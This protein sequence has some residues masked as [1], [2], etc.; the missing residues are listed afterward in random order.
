MI[1]ISLLSLKIKRGENIKPWLMAGPFYKDV[2]E[3]VKTI[4]FFENPGSLAGK[5]VMREVVEEARKI[6]PLSPFEGE[7]I[8]FMDEES[9]WV[10]VRNRERLFSW[11]R[12]NFSNHVCSVFLFT[13]LFPTRSKIVRFELLTGA[14]VLMF[15]EGKGQRQC[16]FFNEESYALKERVRLGYGYLSKYEFE[17]KLGEGSNALFVSLFRMGRTS[18][19][20]FSMK[21]DTDLEIV[22]PFRGDM[23]VGLRERIEEEVNSVRLDRDVFYPCHEIGFSIDKIVP[24]VTLKA[25]LLSLKGELL[26]EVSLER[27]KKV[28]FCRGEDIPDGEYQFRLIWLDKNRK[29]EVT[30]TSFNIA[31]ITPTEDLVG[32]DFL[33]RRKYMTLEHF[34]KNPQSPNFLYKELWSPITGYILGEREKIWSQ[35]AKYALG[36]YSQIDNEV[37]VDVCEFILNKKDCSEFLL[38]AILRLMYWDREKQRLEPEVREIMKKAILNFR[39]WVDE[40]GES[41]MHMGS[42]NHRVLLHAA[43][44]LAGQLFPDKVFYNSGQDG[45]FHA[46][47]GRTYLIEWLR[48]RGKFGFD[49]WNSNCYYT[50]NVAPLVNV[51]DFAP[52][53]DLILRQLVKQ[54][55]DFMFF[56]LAEDSFHGVFGT[57]CGRTYSPYVKYPDFQ[58][59]GS[60]CWLLYGEGSL[61]GGSGMGAVSLATSKYE[62]PRILADIAASSEIV[63]SRQRQGFEDPANIVVYRTPEYMLSSVLDY[64]KGVCA[65]QTHVAQITFK[66]KA[67]VF[68]SSPYS[69]SEGA[70]VRPDYWSGNVVLPRV[71]QYRNVLALIWRR[72]NF[73]WMSHCFLEPSKFDEIRREG[74]WLFARA[75]KGYVGIFSKKGLSFAEKGQ[76]AG[77]EI[78]CYDPD[79]VWLVECGCESEWGSFENFVNGVSLSKIIEGDE[80]LTYHSPSIGEFSVGWK[81]DPTLNGKPIKLNSPY[82]IKS[83][84]ARSLFG[85]GLIAIRHQGKRLELRF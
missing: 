36:L 28:V 38:Q 60:L 19:V 11:G 1:N 71:I 81:K 52:Q 45:L 57:P 16:F 63:E 20:N 6:F 77:R 78:V 44:F 32:F 8:S 17:A 7:K 26:K 14:W 73:F 55:L 27:G 30:N 9:S 85:R 29:Q 3:R 70:G 4:S 10:L 23:D 76:Y 39:F 46:L 84:W 18:A 64:S 40:P 21:C 48:Q 31:K 25:Q 59:T 37:I 82:L 69:S 43:E 67:V 65:P 79:N 15:L 35:V 62:L 5:D 61:W 33:E 74:R 47:K 72:G 22:V 54:V 68:W 53:E 2:G 34:S 51:Y 42:E 41:L 58:Y 12:Y 13:T 83:S 80:G 24:S 49:E 66:N 75:G 56:I 50:V